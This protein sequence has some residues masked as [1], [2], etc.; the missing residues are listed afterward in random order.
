MNVGVGLRD[1]LAVLAM[2]RCGEAAMM[3]QW[4][5]RAWILKPR[6]SWVSD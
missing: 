2:E 1:M 3:I 4:T 6:G 5:E